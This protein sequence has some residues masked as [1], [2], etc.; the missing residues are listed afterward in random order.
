ML[1]ADAMRADI[2]ELLGD[3]AGPID[4]E[5]NLL[6]AGLDSIRIMALIERWRQ[7]GVEVDFLQLAEEPTLAAWWSV[8]RAADVDGERR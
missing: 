4:D 8:V 3:D 5:D 6:D 2:A 1:T 7:R